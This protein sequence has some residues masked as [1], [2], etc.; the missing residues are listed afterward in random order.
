V[1]DKDLLKALRNGT[2]PPHGLARILVG[3]TKINRALEDDLND[4]ERGIS[5]VRFVQGEYGS[6]KTMLTSFFM[7][8]ALDA[9][10]C[11]SQVVI[12]PNIQLGNFSQVYS[13]FCN[14]L[15][16]PSD[17]GASGIAGLLE[18]W[19]AKQFRV[20]MSVE[21]LN[22]EAVDAGVANRFASF[23]EAEM[24]SVR[25]LDP[26][27]ARAVATFAG[28]KVTKNVEQWKTALNWIRGNDSVASSEYAKTLGLRGRIRSDLAYNMLKGLMF[29]IKEVGYRGTVLVLDEVETI[30]RLPQPAQ[31]KKAYEIIRHIIDDIS[32]GQFHHAMV[33]ITAT[34]DF[35]SS[36]RGIQEYEALK[37]RIQQ[38]KASK[39]NASSKQP[40]LEITS[41]SRD[42]YIEL[43]QKLKA[44]H[45][46][47]E[48][49]AIDSRIS[50]E[51]VV[52]L[53]H[54][55]TFGFGNGGEM[56]D[57]IRHIIETF[58][59]LKE[60]EDKTVVDLYPPLR[61]VDVQQ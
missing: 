39:E 33:L 8:K 56:R 9:K 60:H 25:N 3:Q 47:A 42:E 31:R 11:V 1:K 58:D 2:V 4:V 43:A 15:R 52:L 22:P 27:L 26:A 32:A 61:A 19:S 29:L 55:F 34:P 46:E 17:I 12:D 24:V 57:Y 20:F 38:L 23:L 21:G 6:G 36:R 59:L 30:T 54:H 28:G 44:L 10:H 18:E 13:E 40:V 49:W 48:A 51:D 35:F 37:M 53:A 7:E 41:P 16:L 45:G 14:K 5:S 50:D